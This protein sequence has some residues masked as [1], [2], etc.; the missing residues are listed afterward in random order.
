MIALVDSYLNKLFMQNLLT[1]KPFYKIEFQSIK[2][3]LFLTKAKIIFMLI[4]RP[5]LY[6]SI[7]YALQTYVTL[8]HITT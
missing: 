3:K 5:D 6:K 7:N 4:D 8:V 2:G 1:E